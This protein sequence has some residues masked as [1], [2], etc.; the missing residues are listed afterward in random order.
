[1]D[2]RLFLGISLPQIIIK[3]I[4]EIEES[5][6]SQLFWN[7]IENLHITALFLGLIEEE[8]LEKIYKIL[9]ALKIGKFLIEIDKIDYSPGERMLWLYFK[10]NDALKN[11][12]KNI[13]E[14]LEKENVPFQKDNRGFDFLPHINLLK[15]RDEKF[16][17]NNNKIPKAVDLKFQAEEL[18]L[19]ESMLGRSFVI[20][21]IIKT[22]KLV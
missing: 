19:Y 9:D 21:E 16:I 3:D 11:F 7:P 14:F 13:I 8:Y 4:Q 5:I 2:R 1:M 10:E 17:M 22:K 6:G 15:I 20:Y 18:N 12:N